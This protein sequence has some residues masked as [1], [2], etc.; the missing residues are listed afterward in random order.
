MEEKKEGGRG[1]GKKQGMSEAAKYWISDKK[2]LITKFKKK[3][4]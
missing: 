1:G 4:C 3:T 2:V